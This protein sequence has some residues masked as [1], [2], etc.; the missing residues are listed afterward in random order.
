MNIYY[1]GE[2]IMIKWR[3]LDKETKGGL[4]NMRR[5]D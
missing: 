4:Q 2:N 5:G 1:M 3:D